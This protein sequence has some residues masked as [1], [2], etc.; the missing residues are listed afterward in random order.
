MKHIVV[1]C[2]SYCS[3]NRQLSIKVNKDEFGL[4]SRIEKKNSKKHFDLHSNW[5]T[6]INKIY[7]PSL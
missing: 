1:H 4:T 6:L 5:I 3:N 7:L 2:G